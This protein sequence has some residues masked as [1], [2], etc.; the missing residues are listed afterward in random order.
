MDEAIRLFGLKVDSLIKGKNLTREETKNLFRQVLLDEQP[1]LQQGA[2]L[3]AITAKGPTPEELAGAWEAIYE[4]DTVKVTP[5]VPGSL[6]DN[7]G[8]GMDTL[9]TFNVS[10]AASLVAAADGIFMAKHGARAITSKCGVV[11]ILE[12]MGVDVEC[13]A[14]TVKRSIE[15]AG[16]GIFNGMS[17]KIH[18]TALFRILSKIRFGTILNMAG[19]LANPAAPSHGVR[20]VYSKGLV[21]PV[22]ETMKEIGYKKAIVF[23]GLNRDGTKGM[24]EIST[25][26]MT[27]VAELN[28]HGEITTYQLTPEQFGIHDAE[29]SELLFSLD[30]QEEAKLFLRILCGEESGS[31]RDIVCLNASPVLYMMGKAD[32][33]EECY[34]RAIEIIDSGSAIKKLGEWVKA[35]NVN[36]DKGEEKFERLMALAEKD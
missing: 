15:R 30:K 1:E 9:K 31:R 21:V 32:S 11:D 33:L 36:P 6:V 5:D 18:P 10:T 25:L 26:G 2:F 4:I 22:A 16:I 14:E 29:E 12:A 35:Q 17:V 7:C 8:T 3:A 13:D 34:Y 28:D 20:G 23:Y 19:S 24:D 27:H